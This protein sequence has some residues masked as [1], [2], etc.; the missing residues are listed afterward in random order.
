VTRT[1]LLAA[2]PATLS[3]RDLA[4]RQYF[5]DHPKVLACWNHQNGERWPVGYKPQGEP[6]EALSEG[7]WRSE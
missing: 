1:E 7:P 5:L 6:A 2:D 4:W 3:P